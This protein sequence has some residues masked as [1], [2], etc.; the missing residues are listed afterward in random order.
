MAGRGAL[1][2]TALPSAAFTAALLLCAP[3]ARAEGL[4]FGEDGTFTILLLSDAEEE[5]SVSEYYGAA[6]RALIAEHRPDAV[7]VLGDTLDGDGLRYRKD[8]A[9]RNSNATCYP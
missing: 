3:S 7:F 8:P 9:G 1:L 2:R 4:A 6:V 5:P